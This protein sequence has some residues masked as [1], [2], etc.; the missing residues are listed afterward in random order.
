MVVHH[1][2]GPGFGALAPCCASVDVSPWNAWQVGHL[3][4]FFR[5]FPAVKGLD[6]SWIRLVNSMLSCVQCMWSVTINQLE[7]QHVGSR[8]GGGGGVSREFQ[9]QV[10]QHF[11][12]LTASA[13][14]CSCTC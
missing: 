3:Q 11:E 13:G 4:W 10:S 12:I 9:C 2:A 6:S 8:G 7:K 5:D 1:G 14:P